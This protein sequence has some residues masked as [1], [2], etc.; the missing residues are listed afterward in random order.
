M[1]ITT[2]VVNNVSAW[3]MG[4]RDLRREVEGFLKRVAA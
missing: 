1:K 2:G 4:R 3:L